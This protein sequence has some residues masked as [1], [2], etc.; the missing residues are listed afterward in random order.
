LGLADAS[1][2][3]QLILRQNGIP[4]ETFNVL[5]KNYTVEQIVKMIL[6]YSRFPLELKFVDTPLLNQFDYQVSGKKFQNQGF[7]PQDSLSRAIEKTLKLLGAA[8]RGE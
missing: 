8:Y 3:I 4:N 7:I 2:A 6:G 1:T 5:T